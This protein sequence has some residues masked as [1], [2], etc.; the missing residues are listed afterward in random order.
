VVYEGYGPPRYCHFGR[1][2]YRQYYA[3]GSQSPGEAPQA[4]ALLEEAGV[5]AFAIGA[6]LEPLEAVSA[7]RVRIDQ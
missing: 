2:G 4:V 1:N 6:G 5:P 3:N 7:S